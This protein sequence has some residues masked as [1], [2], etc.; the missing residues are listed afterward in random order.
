MRANWISLC[1]LLGQVIGLV[2]CAPPD[3]VN[4]TAEPVKPNMS[5]VVKETNRFPALIGLSG[6]EKEFAR[7]KLLAEQGDAQSQ[8]RLAHKY[9]L[10]KG[11]KKDMKEAV[12]WY[13]VAGNQGESEAQFNLGYMYYNGEGLP[14]NYDQAVEWFE[15]SAAQGNPAALGNLGLMHDN[16]E[17]VPEDNAEALQ[18]YKL[19]AV[20]GPSSMKRVNPSSIKC[21]MDASQRTGEVTCSTSLCKISPAVACGWAVTL[22]IT[23]TAGRFKSTS[24]NAVSSFGHALSIKR[25]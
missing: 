11:V 22:E 19:G 2:S 14:R 21:R 10:G 13:R 23:G 8:T 12:R 3:N 9:A 7:L 6:N 25:E 5:K 1:M 24:R 15:K 17:G 20:P 18:L 4:L 16:G